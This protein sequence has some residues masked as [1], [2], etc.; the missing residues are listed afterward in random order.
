MASAGH[1]DKD[2]KPMVSELEKAHPGVE[3]MLMT[4]VG[5][6]RNFPGL[7]A[8]IAAGETTTTGSPG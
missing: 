4:P 6:D 8:D 3:I 7:I 1:V 5:E 2:I